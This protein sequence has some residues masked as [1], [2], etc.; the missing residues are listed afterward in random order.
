M[1]PPRLP[2]GESAVA[3]WHHGAMDPTPNT[4]WYRRRAARLALELLVIVLIVVAV[5]G[6]MA[7]DVASGEAPVFQAELLDGT[8]VA[9]ADYAGEPLLLYIWATWCHVCR[10]ENPA[11][12]R[13]ARNHPV[14]TIAMQS[15]GP[16]EVA[17]YLDERG[18]AFAT[19]ADL[20][21]ALSRRFGARG[22]PTLLIIDGH[23]A[24]RYRT[25][26][27]TTGWWLRARLWWIRTTG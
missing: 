10:L 18:L 1:T 2:Q 24:I 21:G 8:P 17:D 4:P 6:W 22:V 5:R 16:G 11:I 19:I 3:L 20:D 23:G 14:L 7:R 13:L 12:D 26:G 15:G 25:V 9:L 27:Y